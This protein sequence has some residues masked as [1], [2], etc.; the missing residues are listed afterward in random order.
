MVKKFET[1]IILKLNRNTRIILLL[2]VSMSDDYKC[3]EIIDDSSEPECVDTIAKKAK[4]VKRKVV[5]PILKLC[6]NEDPSVFE[7]GVDEVGR[8]P[9][10]GRVYTAAVILPKDGSFDCSMVKDSKN[11]IQKEDRRGVAICKGKRAGV[12]HQF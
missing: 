3:A 2:Y 5:Q 12:V 9:L 1:Y 8:G 11:F 4:A 10:F 6:Y 7:I